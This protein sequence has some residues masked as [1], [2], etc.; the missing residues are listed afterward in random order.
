SSIIWTVVF[1]IALISILKRTDIP[2]NTKLLWLIVIFLIA[3]LGLLIYVL[4]NFK[5]AK[6]LLITGIIALILIA[7]SV[8]YF[9]KY[10]PEHN[11]RS[12]ENEKGL[13]V[14]A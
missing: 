6:S 5:K 9:I 1:V 2:A 3:G 7:A 12:V 8:W 11:R 13:V 4:S 10:D 14:N